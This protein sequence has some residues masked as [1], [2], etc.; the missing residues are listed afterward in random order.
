MPLLQR[1]CNALTV[2]RVTV[3]TD[4][5]RLATLATKKM[6][7]FRSDSNLDETFHT[8]VNKPSPMPVASV[9]RDL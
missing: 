7:L 9:A 6:C 1:P 4:L 2:T 8:L 3:A 5:Q